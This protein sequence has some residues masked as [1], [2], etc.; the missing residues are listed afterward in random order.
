MVDFYARSAAIPIPNVP[1]FDNRRVVDGQRTMIFYKT[2]PPT[3]VGKQF[4][5]R[6]KVVGVYDKGKAGT[7]VDTETILVEKGGDVYTKAVGSAFFVGQ[8]NWGGPKGGKIL[9]CFITA[10]K[11]YYRPSHYQ[12]PATRGQEA[13][14]STYTSDY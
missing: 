10:S 3:S 13:G 11:E 8:G 6:S 9:C 5:L 7:V 2:I 14:C 1:K 4:E 12:L